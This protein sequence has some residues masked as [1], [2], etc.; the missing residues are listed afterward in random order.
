VGE[1]GGLVALK[2]LSTIKKGTRPLNFQSNEPNYNF[3]NEIIKLSN[4]FFFY[5]LVIAVQFAR[6]IKMSI[7]SAISFA[8]NLQASK[9]II[10]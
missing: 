1:R 5:V 2:S 10:L 9:S 8:V 4:R 3:I 7:G 6:R